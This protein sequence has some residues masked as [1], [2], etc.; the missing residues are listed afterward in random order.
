MSRIELHAHT[1]FSDGVL[2]P[3]QVVRVAAAVGLDAIAISDHDTQEGVAPAREAAAGSSVD[4]IPGVEISCIHGT[5]QVHV[6]GYWCSEESELFHELRKIRS[7]R[8]ARAESMVK[9]LNDLGF[10]I[11]FEQVMRIA[12][13]GNPGR[14]HIARALIEIGAIE[15][16]KDAFTAE[17]IAT[18]G[19][20]YVEKYA[21]SP[22][23][24]VELVRASGGASVLAHPA[25]HAGAPVVNDELIREM[26]DAG[27]AGLEA[28]HI[29]H[30]PS[31][32]ERYRELAKELN[33]VPTAGSDC[34]GDPVL[35]GSRTVDENT[36]DRLHARRI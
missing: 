31:D 23:H 17:L 13:G 6:L 2:S 12:E 3:S 20:G 30:L 10:P 15:E 7:S 33:L 34:H 26:A 25:S 5:M 11:T 24:A 4:V 18:G 22:L 9:K 29:D 8:V 32:V 27:M 21:L 28:D 14:P 35:M 19:R 36:I 1:H 16:V